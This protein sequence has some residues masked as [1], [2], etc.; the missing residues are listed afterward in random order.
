MDQEKPA[1]DEIDIGEV[2]RK[3]GSG[4]RIGWVGFMRFLAVLRAVPIENKFTFVAIIVVSNVMALSY[5]VLLDEEYYESTMVVSSQYLNK[6]LI[7]I[8]IAKLDVLAEEKEDAGLARV[9]GIPDSLAKDVIGFSGR[10]YLSEAELI[11]LELLKEQI[12]TAGQDVEAGITDEILRRIEIENRHTFEITVRTLK[13]DVMPSLQEALVNYIKNSEFVRRRLYITKTGLEERRLKLAS[14]LKKIDSIKM[15]INANYRQMA[16]AGR[17][18]S[19]NVILS[20]RT[21]ADPIEVVKQDLKLYDELQFVDRQLYLQTDFEVIDGLTEFSEPA[22]PTIPKLILVAVLIG[23]LVAYLD[24]AL[25]SF[26]K[27]LANIK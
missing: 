4:I 9:L 5:S 24:V 20:D 26:D 12:R 14:E 23:F 10:T 2:V 16:E 7:D 21:V 8:T 18:G 22:S 19:N 15:L 6:R 13:A 25:R 27:Y 17:S 1:S 11:D 3:I